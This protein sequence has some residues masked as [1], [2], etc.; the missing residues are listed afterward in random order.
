[1]TTELVHGQNHPLP[2]TLL[3]IRVSAGTPVVAGVSLGDGQGRV[4]GPEAVAHPGAPRLPGIEVPARL[5]AEQRLTADLAAVPA[6]VDRVHVLLALP[7]VAGAPTRFGACPAPHLTVAGPDGAPVVSFT[8]TGLGTETAIVALE[9]YRRQGSW[10]VR[11]LGQGYAGGLAELL[12]D[13]GLGRP[14]ADA[15][16]ARMTDA[17]RPAPVVPSPTP[18]P[19]APAP[20]PPAPPTPP[21]ADA[22]PPHTVPPT[23][24]PVAGDASG[25]S[26]EERLYNQVWG[27]FE[28]LARTIAAY[29][30]AVDFAES[31][32]DQELDTI[33]ADPRTRVGPA[34][35]AA[36][37]QARARQ[38][39]LTDRARAVL[40][41]DLVQL[42][43]ESEVVEPALPPPYA[44]WGSPV[45]HGYRT[46]AEPPMAVRI[47]DLHLPER[48]DLRIPLL[49]RMPLERGLW[50]DSAQDRRRAMDVAVALAARLL[51]SHPAGECAVHVIDPAGSAVA[52]L[53]PFTDSGALREPP[54]T[55]AAGVAALL[56]RLT[57][58]VD[59]VQMALRADAPPE[60]P[61]GVDPARQVLVVNDFPYGF[62]DRTVN[63]LRYLADEGPRVGV[64]LILVGDRED[65]REYGP[66]LDPLWRSMM[67]L[68]PVPDDHLADP[69]V[70]HAWTYEPLLAPP[71]SG[72]VPQVL[73][74]VAA[75]RRT[76]DPGRH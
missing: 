72:I 12:R 34:A 56:A 21:P 62:D 11:A 31:R 10:K 33:L 27:M 53:A 15:V 73:R 58:R 38:A 8:V 45:W 4:S 7:P 76:Y 29:R 63:Q 35:E 47:G 57:Q 25:W 75:A 13:Q 41:R 49:L 24:A 6:G 60:L 36:R 67:R 71:G 55:G 40:D 64:H 37:D 54:A 74:Q 18:P 23:P 42:I 65:A 44:G 14:E 52:A 19:A 68:T 39:E 46:P 28:D 61:P 43:A 59:L 26:M 5:A 69:W 66:L 2:G 50:V 3:E 22:V 70:G 51:A 48:P 20:P 17:V 30:S 16:A 32:L 9:L 1:M